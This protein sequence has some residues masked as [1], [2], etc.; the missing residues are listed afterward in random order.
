LHF[1]DGGHFA[2][3]THGDEIAA[4]MRGFLGPLLH[5]PGTPA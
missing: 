5:Q 2:L 4:L 3:E 1:L